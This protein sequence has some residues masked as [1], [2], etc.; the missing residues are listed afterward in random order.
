[1]YGVYKIYTATQVGKASSSILYGVFN[2]P[3]LQGF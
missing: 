1:M 3:F 2:A